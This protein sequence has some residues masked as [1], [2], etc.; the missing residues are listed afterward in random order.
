MTMQAAIINAPTIM[1]GNEGWR[2]LTPIGPVLLRPALAL[3]PPAAGQTGA[4]R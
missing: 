2:M 4:C 1:P 3:S